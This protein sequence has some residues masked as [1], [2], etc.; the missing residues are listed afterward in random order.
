MTT[1]RGVARGG[2]KGALAP[3]LFSQKYNAKHDACPPFF[4]ERQD[5]ALLFLTLTV[6]KV[7]LVV[8]RAGKDDREAVYK[9]IS[10]KQA[11]EKLSTS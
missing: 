3:P 10:S 11:I 4:P 6:V 7:A 1:D 2:A 5:K 8:L 9:A